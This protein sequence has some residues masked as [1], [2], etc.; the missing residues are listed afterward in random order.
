MTM[1]AT[2]IK[3]T[4]D[5]FNVI[6]KDQIAIYWN[7]RWAE[8]P[9]GLPENEY[10]EKEKPIMAS[11]NAALEQYEIIPVEVNHPNEAIVK[12][13]QRTYVSK[14]DNIYYGSILHINICGDWNTWYKILEDMGGW[15]SNSENGSYL[16]DSAIYQKEG[17][18]TVICGYCEGDLDFEIK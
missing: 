12:L 9:E 14:V 17:E 7:R 4:Q 8:I 10:W 18:P 3:V 6:L 2:K 13:I 1:S 5:E 16:V 15:S 11:M